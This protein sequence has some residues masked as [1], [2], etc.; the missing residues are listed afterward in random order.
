[1]NSLRYCFA[2]L[3]LADPAPVAEIE[4]CWQFVDLNESSPTEAQA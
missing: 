1:M 4:T 3:L 2:Q